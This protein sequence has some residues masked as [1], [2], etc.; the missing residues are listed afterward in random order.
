[1]SNAKECDRG[2]IIHGSVDYYK[3]FLKGFSNIASPITSLQK[4][5][6][7]FEWI[8]KCEESFQQLKGILKSAPILKIE[9]PNE[10]F[11][12]CIDACKEGLGGFLSRKDHVVCYESKK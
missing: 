4:K 6:V 12:V 5:R 7:K 2:H 11:V 1:M 8:S 3:S 10:Y 9:D